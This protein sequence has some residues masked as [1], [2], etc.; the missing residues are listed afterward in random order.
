MR[1]V[2]QTMCDATEQG[3]DKRAVPARSRH[4]EIGSL[5]VGDFHNH[6]RRVSCR[7]LRQLD[8]CVE[9]FL[10]QVLDLLADRGLY[11]VLI[12][13]RISTCGRSTRDLIYVDQDE[14]GSIRL[15]ETLGVS[16][17]LLGPA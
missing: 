15:R 11:L 13:D 3:T 5:L 7:R 6:I 10:L 16:E 17:C 9:T 4:D 14:P 8:V 2:Q 12:A 1:Y